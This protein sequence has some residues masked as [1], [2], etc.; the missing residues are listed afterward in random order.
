MTSPLKVLLISGSSRQPSHT[1]T[2]VNRIA[3]VLGGFGAE[4]TIWLLSERALPPANPKY[5]QVPSSHPDPLV[6]QLVLQA[7][8][9]GGIVLASPVYHN[10]YSGV[11][12][13]ALDHLSIDQFHRKPVS[14]AG[15]GGNRTT[16]AVDHLRIVVRGLLGVA[17]PSQV[18]TSNEDFEETAGVYRVASADIETRVQRMGEELILFAQTLQL[19]RGRA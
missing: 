6:R 2:L 11:L 1:A 8:D 18:C 15:H 10:S 4:T 13:N 14:L 19:L 7:E 17:L 5:H 16:Q 9:A 3:D 12:K